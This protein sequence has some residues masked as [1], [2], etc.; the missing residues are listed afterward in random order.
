ME[1][2]D[3]E[4]RLGKL[5]EEIDQ[6][7]GELLPLFLRR[8]DCSQRVA[9]LKKEAGM[10][11]FAPQREQA[12]LEQGP[13]AR[14]ERGGGRGKPV[15]L[16]YGNQPGQAAC[17]APGRRSSPGAGADCRPHSPAG[18]RAGVCQGVPG[19]FS[20]RAALDFF[21]QITPAFE[22][23][24]R[25]SLRTCSGQGGLWRAACGKLRGRGLSPR[26]TT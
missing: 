20:H 12:I 17:A 10:A 21:G 6:I 7:D 2:S 11:V 1:P 25:E 4:A 3:Y 22:P 5:R 14:W 18:G 24:F 13:P 23:S 15:Q 19:A 16:H 8:M 9:Q 26:C